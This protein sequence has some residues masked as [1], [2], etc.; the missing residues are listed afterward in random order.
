MIRLTIIHFQPLEKYPPIVNLLNY[1]SEKQIATV[2]LTTNPPHHLEH[3]NNDFHKIHRFP[4]ING[5][6]RLRIFQYLAFYI[7]SIV[8]LI[9]RRPSHL[10]WIET[11]S[12]FPA[13][14]YYYLKAKKPK[15]FVHYHEY[16]SPEEIRNGMY[17]SHIFHWMEKKIYPK[18]TW[19]SHTNQDRMDLFVN[20]NPEVNPHSLRIMPNY[21]PKWWKDYSRDYKMLGTPVKLVYV[22]ALS[23]ETTYFKELLQLIHET[24]GSLTCD[25]YSFSIDNKTQ[26]LFD[27]YKSPNIRFKGVVSQTDF[28][29]VISK[30]HVGLIL[31]KGHI[32]N[33]IFNAPNKLFE[34]LACGLDVWYP[35]KMKGPEPY[36]RDSVYPKVLS[37]DFEDLDSFNWKSAI[38]R[39]GLK[40]EK[41]AYY[42]EEVYKELVEAILTPLSNK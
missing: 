34:Y 12:A 41:S 24:N 33:Y 38:S 10:F 27:Q 14:I 1:L 42:C 3:Y 15:L 37:I 29:K 20:D 19:M 11:L 36:K 28:P 13:I 31:Y 21:P 30:Y 40:E 9:K 25:F 39:E 16:E 4:S 8:Q 5:G 22:G 2:V 35:N 32:P 6:S 18:L 17:L 7:G 26:S 23:L